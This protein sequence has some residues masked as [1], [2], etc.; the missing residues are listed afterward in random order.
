MSP[1]DP[2]GPAVGPVVL[3]GLMGAG[4]TTVGRRVA[5]GCGGRFVD[6]D[7]EIVRRAGRTVPAI[8]NA[9]GEVEFRRLEAE[10]TRELAVAADLGEPG[11]T[12]RA[13]PLVVAA[14]GG[15]MTNRDAR[16]ALPGA[17]TVWLRVAPSE[18][19]RRLAV[20]V[21]SRP[22]L[23]GVDAEERLEALLAERLPAYGEATYTVETD[24]RTPEDVAR[25]VA[26]VTGLPSRADDGAGRAP[27][28]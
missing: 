8:F 21:A 23:E 24:G 22:L 13:G 25:A 20:H 15:W 9:G 5:A 18:A 16:A 7:A 27:G 3:V 11:A 10:A 19:A 2:T 28:G 12:A 14:G 6:L 1:K 26:S 4:K 17:K